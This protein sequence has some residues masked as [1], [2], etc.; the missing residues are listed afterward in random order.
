MINFQEEI[1]KYQPIL[2]VDDVEKA[3][4]TDEVKDILDLLNHI[5]KQVSLK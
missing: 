2:G 4:K 1:L 5:T 3:I